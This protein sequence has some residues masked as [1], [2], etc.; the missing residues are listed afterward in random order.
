MS[1]PWRASCGCSPTVALTPANR[2]A[3]SS[4]SIDEA[5]SHPTVTIVVTPAA[6]ASATSSAASSAGRWQ[7]ESSQPGR[8][9][10]VIRGNRAGPLVTGSPPG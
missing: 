1:T 6:P 9:H 4:A 3:T 2:P 5:R 7:C 10:V 8:R